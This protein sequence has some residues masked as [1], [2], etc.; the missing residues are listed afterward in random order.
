MSTFKLT[1]N[2][3]RIAA[4]GACL[5]MLA[6]FSAVSAWETGTALKVHMNSGDPQFFMLS[7]EPV[8]TF[9]GSECVIKSS[10][11]SARFD[12]G[13]VY[14][15][16]L[17]EHTT[18]I[19]DEMKASLTV[20]LTDPNAVVIRGMNSGSHVSLYN[21]SGVQLRSADA[22]ATGEAILNISELPAA[23]YIV[24]SKETSFKIYKK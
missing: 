7:S 11:I 19:D 17:V 23:V 10:D 9:E 24:T 2:L 18:A 14:F 15:A 6:P 8:I 20:D 4:L 3:R 21:L 22:D 5:L 1:T 16:E 13:D 12:M